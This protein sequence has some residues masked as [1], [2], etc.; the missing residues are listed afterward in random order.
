MFNGALVIASILIVNSSTLSFSFFFDMSF[1]LFATSHTFFDSIVLRKTFKRFISALF[2]QDSKSFLAS[3]PL[4]FL[5][6]SFHQNFLSIKHLFQFIYPF[7]ANLASEATALRT[8]PQ[9]LP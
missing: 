8:R 6:S 3:R 5:R 9:P 2:V 1:F 7:V 4:Y